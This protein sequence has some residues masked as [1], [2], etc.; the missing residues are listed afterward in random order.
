MAFVQDSG[1]TLLAETW[2]AG[3]ITSEH[4]QI[5]RP[6]QHCVH[7]PRLRG[8]TAVVED[9]IQQGLAASRVFDFCHTQSSKFSHNHAKKIKK[10]KKARRWYTGQHNTAG[11]A[12]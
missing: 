5:G 3:I 6:L 2:Q 9:V 12:T 1:R 8:G 10:H 4:M 7:S 11:H